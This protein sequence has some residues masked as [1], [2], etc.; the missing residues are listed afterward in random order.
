MTVSP[1]NKCTGDEWGEVS[2]R[3]T[4]R[5][6]RYL[7]SEFDRPQLGK[8]C[9]L[10]S[11]RKLAEQLQVSN[12]TVQKAFQKLAKEGRIQSEV[13]NGSFF[14]PKGA[15]GNPSLRIGLNIAVPRGASPSDWIYQ[16]YGGIFHGVMEASHSLTL[17][18]LPHE[19][20]EKEDYWRKLQAE[21][22]ELDGFILFPFTYSKRLRALYE[23]EGRPYVDLNPPS[24]GTTANF[25]SPDYYEASRRLGTVWRRT[26]RRRIALVMRPGLEQSVSVRLRCS[27]FLA[28]V[29]DALGDSVA[30][31]MLSLAGAD[32]ASGNALMRD[33]LAKGDYVP[34]AIYCAGDKLAFGVLDAIRERGL[35]VPDDISVVGGNGLGMRSDP[36]RRLTGMSHPLEALGE[37]L[38]R[39]LMERITTGCRPVPG[40]FLSVSFVAGETTRAEEN[41]L[42][43]SVE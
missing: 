24:E 17:Q 23:S 3:P 25:V 4:E 13:G 18:S 6:I 10:P 27:G 36:S 19:A 34:D 32:Q 37:E 35:S 15:N 5:V 28:G 40:R 30:V 38:I 16:V 21:C 41:A 43:L 1:E 8:E 29:G 14:I 7:I 31:R 33:L 2:L 9:R 11:V 20:F 42:L 22:R 26:G 12:T 39:M